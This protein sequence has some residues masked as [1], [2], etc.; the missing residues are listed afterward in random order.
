MTDVLRLADVEPGAAF[1]ERLSRLESRWKGLAD[2]PEESPETT[3]RALWLAAAG[4]PCSVARADGRSLGRLGAD[5]LDMLDALIERRLSGVPLAHITGRQSFMGLE[6]LAGP[7]ALIPR[8]ETELLGR[9]SVERVRQIADEIG[10]ATVLDLCTG[11]GNLALSLAHHEP[12][13]S[14]VGSDISPAA[15]ALA[16]RNAAA[17]GLTDRVRFVVGD[18]FAPIQEAGLEG[19]ADLICCNPPYISTA[20]VAAM[21]TEIAEFEPRLAF[22]GGAFG[23][24]ILFRLIAG[25]PQFLRPGGWLVFEIGLGQGE[26]MAVRLERSGSYTSIE[27]VRDDGGNVRVLAA[28]TRFTE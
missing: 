25:A 20:K 10:Q 9:T 12:R 24:A 28:R 15:I 5:Q 4:E 16:Q 11:S 2:K 18:L 19:T 1:A 3:L 26:P 6:L 21:A 27:Q 7:E 14:V 17:L 8:A 22:D 23:I 13:C